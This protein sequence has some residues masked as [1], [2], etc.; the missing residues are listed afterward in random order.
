MEALE[1]VSSGSSRTATGDHTKAVA[2]LRRNIKTISASDTFAAWAGR[3][4]R[5]DPASCHARLWEVL[6]SEV[7]RLDDAEADFAASVMRGD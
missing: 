5:V 2:L 1:A 3:K 6:A 7:A 4:H